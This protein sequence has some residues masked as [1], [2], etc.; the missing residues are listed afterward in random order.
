MK[1]TIIAA[2]LLGA[3]TAFAAA[4]D[5]AATDIEAGKATI[6]Y[7]AS[8]AE[9]FEIKREIVDEAQAAF[10]EAAAYETPQELPTSVNAEIVPG[11]A[12]PEGAATGEVPAELG[13]LPTLA[14]EGSHWVAAG[15]HLVEVT[16]DN[17]IV[18]VVYNALP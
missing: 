16:D 6:V 5:T 3:G 2:L 7:D 18:M 14:D 17:M 4:A 12:L 15:N 9:K 10:G 1:R 11:N 13:D 8:L